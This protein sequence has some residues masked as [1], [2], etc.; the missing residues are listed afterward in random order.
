[1]A[2]STYSRELEFALDICKRVGNLVLDYWRKGVDTNF[3]SDNSPLTVTDKEAER[4]NHRAI[5]QTFPGD[6]MVGEEEGSSVGIGTAGSA[7]KWIIDPIDGTYN[8]VRGIPFFSTLLALEEDGDIIVGVIHAP[9]AGDTYWAARH[10]GAYKNGR[11]VS[12]SHIE[13]LDKSQFNFGGLNRVFSSGFGKG[14][15]QIVKS[16]YRQ[17]G[18]GDYLSLGYVFEGKAEAA[19]EVGVCAWDLAP[20]KVLIEEAGGRYSDLQGGDSIYTGSCLISNGLVH[21]ELLEMLSA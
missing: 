3:K 1:M 16:T 21:E 8:F 10:A 2:Q 15:E 7:R 17:R 14:F 18:F 13:T 19:L 9:A 4:A 12:V 11:S 6:Q 5:Q 20:V